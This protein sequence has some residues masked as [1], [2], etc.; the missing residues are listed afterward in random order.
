M[1]Q[2]FIEAGGPPGVFN[3]VN[4]LGEVAGAALALHNDV[5]KDRVPRLDRDRQADADLRRPVQY[6]ARQPG[7]R[8]KNSADIPRHLPDLDTA[9]TYAING[10]IG[11]T[12]RDSR[13]G[14]PR[15]VCRRSR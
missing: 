5:A 4:G 13:V 6:E 11:S 14:I 7:M 15:H 1:A 12:C 8:R 3:V 2:L 9:V 10:T